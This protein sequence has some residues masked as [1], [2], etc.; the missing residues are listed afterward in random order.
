[1]VEL[2]TTGK[3]IKQTILECTEITK[4]VTVR[5][6]K[7]G[8]VKNQIELGKVI[9]WYY[10]KGEQGYI[11]YKTNG[12]KVPKSDGGKPLMDLPAVFPS[13]I[14]YDWYIKEAE[15]ILFDIGYYKKA[16]PGKL[17]F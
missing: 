10:A 12:N 4:F 7:G 9:R 3:A 16:T 5:D 17:F 2:I 1:M 11:E 14:N 8:A 6:V 13:D 15:S